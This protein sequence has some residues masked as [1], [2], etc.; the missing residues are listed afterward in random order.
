M[1]RATRRTMDAALAGLGRS[2]V[3]VRGTGAWRAEG[4]SSFEEFA[5]ATV[6]KRLAALAGAGVPVDDG[7]VDELVARALALAAGRRP[8]GRR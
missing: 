2:L 1:N 6:A 8:K 7:Q 4:F 5:R 3:R